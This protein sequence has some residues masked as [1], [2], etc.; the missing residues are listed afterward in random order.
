MIC[1]EMAFVWAVEVFSPTFFDARMT[2]SAPKRTRAKNYIHIWPQKDD[3]EKKVS[4]KKLE[5][6]AD[7]KLSRNKIIM[8]LGDLDNTFFYHVEGGE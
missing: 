4:S 8:M 2:H 1:L 5:Y 3:E 7:T 6:P